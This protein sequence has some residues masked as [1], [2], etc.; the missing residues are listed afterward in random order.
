MRVAQFWSALDWW[1]GLVVPVLVTAFLLLVMPW[2]AAVLEFINRKV[3]NWRVDLRLEHREHEVDQETKLAAKEAK[4]TRIRNGNA[5]YEELVKRNAELEGLLSDIRDELKQ[6]SKLGATP[7][8]LRDE[9]ENNEKIY[10]ENIEKLRSICSDLYSNVRKVSKEFKELG[11]DE[12]ILGVLSKAYQM[13][14][15]LKIEKEEA[16]SRSFRSMFDSLELPEWN[17]EAN[18]TK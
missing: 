18:N 4:L 12:R 16:A 15:M 1:N 7:S 17:S 6:Y 13:N 3:K 10:L 9:I 5:E 14:E 11:N 2:L 8:E